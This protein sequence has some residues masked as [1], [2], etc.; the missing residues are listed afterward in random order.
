MYFWAT[1]NTHTP[2]PLTHTHNT[3]RP[4]VRYELNLTKAGSG[5]EVS[6]MALTPAELSHTFGGLDQNTTYTLVYLSSMDTY[7]SAI[8]FSLKHTH[9]K[10]CL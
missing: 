3:G 6:A 4:I 5:S 9:E 2:T 7:L 8:I 1:V 10:T